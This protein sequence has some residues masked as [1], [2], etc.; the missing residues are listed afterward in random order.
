MDRAP[1]QGGK[2]R[3]PQTPLLLSCHVPFG[4]YLN[5]LYT[6]K[7]RMEHYKD[8]RARECYKLVCD[9]LAYAKEKGMTVMIEED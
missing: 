7:D 9:F 6:Y 3:P 1:R 8:E 5:D 2:P 4:E